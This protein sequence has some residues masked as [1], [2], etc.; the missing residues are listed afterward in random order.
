MLTGSCRTILP[1]RSSHHLAAPP[2]RGNR[3]LCCTCITPGCPCAL[4][5]SSRAELYPGA[6]AQPISIIRCEVICRD[7]AARSPISTQAAPSGGSQSPCAPGKAALCCHSHFN[8]WSRRG[9]GSNGANLWHINLLLVL[10]VSMIPSPRAA[11][12]SLV[13]EGCPA[14][15]SAKGTIL[16]TSHDPSRGSSLFPEASQLQTHVVRPV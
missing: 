4:P 10:P 15:P 11:P 16:G 3:V 8:V 6:P 7:N 12:P 1:F 9:L 2:E 5:G 13:P 14:V